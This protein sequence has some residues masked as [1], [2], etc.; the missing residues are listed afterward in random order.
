MVEEVV[1]ASSVWYTASMALSSLTVPRSCLVIVMEFVHLKHKSVPRDSVT[2]A[3][4][5]GPIPS[6]A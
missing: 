3:L 6:V 2:D 4:R 1:R 5:L